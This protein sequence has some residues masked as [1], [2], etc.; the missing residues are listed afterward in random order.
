MRDLLKPNIINISI[1]YNSNV[2]FVRVLENLIDQSLIYYYE[3]NKIDETLVYPFDY[4]KFNFDLGEFEGIGEKERV[5]FELVDL[6]DDFKLDYYDMVILGKK[7]A[8]TV[9]S[10]KDISSF[11]KMPFKEALKHYQ[12]HVIGKGLIFAYIVTLT[13]PDYRLLVKFK[14][15]DVLNYLTRIPE[16]YS[17]FKLDD[18]SYI[19][20]ILGRNSTLIKYL[21]FISEAK[22][23]FDDDITVNIHPA[24]KDHIY[25]ASIPYEHY[26]NGKWEFNPEVMIM[27]AEKIAS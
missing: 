24:D 2:N 9:F 22:R 19:G 8:R 26:E 5:P 15:D 11:F 21:E 14:N 18:G 17:A 20:H 27:R 23:K 3:L 16:F 13:I 6:S 1:Y 10:L 12:G 7:Q 4:S 25:T